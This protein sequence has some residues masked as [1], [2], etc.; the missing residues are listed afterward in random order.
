[1]S[2]YAGGRNGS[3]RALYRVVLSILSKDR[4]TD[5]RTY[6]FAIIFDDRLGAFALIGTSCS[7]L[8]F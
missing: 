8:P 5:V 4:R 6:D 1:M 3:S 7:S 2:K